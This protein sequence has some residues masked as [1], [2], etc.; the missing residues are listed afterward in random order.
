MSILFQA[1]ENA[2]EL[3]E[4][5]E[6]EPAL[7][8]VKKAENMLNRDEFNKSL[9]EKE[10][11]EILS[12]LE[13]FKGFNY[14]ALSLVEEAKEAF[15]KSLNINP[16][17]SQACAGMGEVFYIIE[18]NEEAKIMFEWSLD[19]APDNQFAVAGLAKV[20]KKMRL[21]ENHNTLNLDTSLKRKDTF[22]NIL[23]EA[24]RL[25]SNHKFEESLAKL[26][27]IE[28]ILNQSVT[29]KDAA[30]KI[31]SLENFRGFNYLSLQRYAEA[32]VCFER[33]LNI[34]PSSSQSC[35]GLAEILFLENQ[36][37]EAKSMYEWSV[38]N[39]PMNDFAVEGLK[40][41]NQLLGL[42]LT[43]NTLTEAI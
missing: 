9:S 33:A 14:L 28:K 30:K 16:N 43:H 15:E 6:F 27:E 8:E 42:P 39:N 21:P 29:A 40:K 26:V 38:K 2:Y 10:K 13:N 4:R 34:N 22:Y 12:S 23:S 5:K 24:Y 37:K 1:I 31:V 3:F 25:F 7:E 17:S 19:N 20:N 41:V 18:Q 32:K 35:A 11:D 36:E